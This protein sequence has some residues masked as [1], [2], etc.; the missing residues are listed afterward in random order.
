M[1]QMNIA[2]PVKGGL[3]LNLTNRCPCA[4]TFCIRQEGDGVYGSSSLWLSH[5]PDFQEVEAALQEAGFAGYREIIF[6]G[7]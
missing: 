5:E 7:Y 1:K 6:C 4:C 2:Y 3:Y